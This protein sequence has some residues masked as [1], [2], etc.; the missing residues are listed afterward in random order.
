MWARQD[1]FRCLGCATV[2]LSY[3]QLSIKHHIYVI[4]RLG[5]NLLGLPAI[6]ALNIL[7]KVDAI[8]SRD[9]FILTKFSNLFQGLGTMHCEYGIQL[10]PDAK[11]FSLFTACKIPI[12]LCDKVQN[13]IARMEASGV[14]SKV[15]Q[16]TE[17]CSGMVV[18]QKKSGDVRICVDLKHL[19]E[20]VL[21]EVHPMPQVDE[22][23]ALLSGA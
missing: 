11:P 14:I 21:W 13:E 9:N 10:K 20:N 22:T 23:L 7:V 1:S 4:Q 17:W 16:P 3:K 6:T 18:V 19:N 15:D 2:Q 12:P 8:H 5:N